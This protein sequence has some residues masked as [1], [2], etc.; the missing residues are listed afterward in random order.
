M[1]GAQIKHLP[2]TW[3]A[4]IANFNAAGIRMKLGSSRS[5]PFLEDDKLD[6][7]FQ[8]WMTL[9]TPR[10]VVEFDHPGQMAKFT[11]SLNSRRRYYF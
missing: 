7:P 10:L 11:C 3:Q 8:G 5:R 1:K 6:G 2:A 4:I 9:Q